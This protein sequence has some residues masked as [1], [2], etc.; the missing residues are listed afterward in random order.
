MSDPVVIT[1]RSAPLSSGTEN[2]ADAPQP[3][4]HQ[5]PDSNK[6]NLL[7]AIA[8]ALALAAV[9]WVFFVLPGTINPKQ[10][11]LPT[12]A[13]AASGVEQSS[14]ASTPD[15]QSGDDT[16]PVAPFRDIQLARAKDQAEKELAT[17]VELQ[18]ELE[19]N[20]QID[21]WGQSRYNALK[22][23]ATRGDTEFQNREFEKANATYRAATQALEELRQ[24]AEADYAAGIK[25]GN[26]A[27]ADFNQLLAVRQF[28]RAQT[29]KAE[30]PEALAGL[31]RAELL[32]EVQ[33]LLRKARQLA[34]RG[35][36]QAATS[37]YQEVVQLDPLTAG[38]SEA[39][40]EL[41]QESLA[42][43]Y[44]DHLSR[45]FAALE[46]GR[47]SSAR[48]SFNA[49]LA[50]RPNDAVAKGGLQQIA[51]ETEVLGLQNLQ[52]AAARAVAEERW[53]D[54]VKA[55]DQALNKDKNLAFAQSGRAEAIER[56][57]L[58]RGMSLIINE[59]EKLSD[60]SRMQEAQ[61][62]LAEAAALPSAG[63]NWSADLEQAQA[64]VQSYLSPVAVRL[65]SDNATLVTVYK[66]GRIGTFTT[67]DLELR[68]GAY[69]IVGSA[70]G[71]QDVRKEVIVKPQMPPVEIRC[72]NRL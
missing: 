22:D 46:R 59:S 47:H 39:L 63:T 64:T 68:P 42:A 37:T 52:R 61:S 24:T 15:N 27:L 20:L 1:P 58:Q 54:A 40:A 6:R 71:C 34:R 17:F 67:H 70:D 48:K 23:L 62:L 33:S 35:D 13:A 11:V 56:R 9:Y 49:A 10:V 45:G 26:D 36:T 51:Q 21:R 43:D 28:E 32:P 41:A 60:N 69:T 53:D 8:A 2:T 25:A 31:Q 4:D 18:I 19:D 14:Q 44:R 12:D 66:V 50:I 7:I 30:S 5:H 29:I 57:R 72:E 55:Y 65:T 3:P 38:V 16:R